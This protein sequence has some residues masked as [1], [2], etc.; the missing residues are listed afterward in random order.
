MNAYKT[1]LI[2]RAGRLA[3]ADTVLEV[4]TNSINSLP[5]DDAQRIWNGIETY[6]LHSLSDI[7]NAIYQGDVNGA[8]KALAAKACDKQ[9]PQRNWFKRLLDKLRGKSGAVVSENPE[10]KRCFCS[11]CQNELGLDSLIAND[12]TKLVYRC[13]ICGTQITLTASSELW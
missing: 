7:D 1:K 3:L 5:D 11:T 6:G 2:A 12:N 10:V 9:E 13:G 8:Y 4:M